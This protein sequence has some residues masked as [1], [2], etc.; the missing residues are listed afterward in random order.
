MINDAAARIVITQEHLPAIKQVKQKVQTVYLDSLWDILAEEC[1][2]NPAL[3]LHGEH[4]AYIIYTSG[5]TG[6][7]KGVLVAHQAIAQHIQSIKHSFAMSM[8]DHVLQFSTTSFDTSLEQIFP[9]LCTGARLILR[10]NDVWTG[11]GIRSKDYHVSLNG[12]GST[13]KLLAPYRAR[14]EHYPNSI[15]MHHLRLISVGGERLLPEATR[16]LHYPLYKTFVCSMPM[17]QLKQPLP[18]PSSRF[19]HT[20]LLKKFLLVTR[21]L[22]N[23]S[24]S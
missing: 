13:R 9:A 23:L 15:P 16:S 8:H 20:K 19:R 1:D 2:D 10:N 22:I 21:L 7:P 17:G 24:T 3:T 6:T 4:A 14:M 12:D 5:S 18:Q 11:C